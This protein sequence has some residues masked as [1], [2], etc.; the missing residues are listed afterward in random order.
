MKQV[1]RETVLVSAGAPALPWMRA[2][3]TALGMRYAFFRGGG[4]LFDNLHQNHV[5]LTIEQLAAP[6]ALLRTRALNN[7]VHDEGLDAITLFKRGS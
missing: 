3:S 4:R 6:I 7:E 2:W 5:E 1:A